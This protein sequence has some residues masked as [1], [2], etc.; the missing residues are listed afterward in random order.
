MKD[1]YHTTC[2]PY[3]QGQKN[4]AAKRDNQAKPES[5]DVLSLVKDLT[6]G[7][8][9]SP[10]INADAH[11]SQYHDSPRL[12]ATVAAGITLSLRIMIMEIFLATPM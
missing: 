1:G 7:G 11:C 3:S 10:Q 6:S 12:S 2:S 5:L 9:S 4:H 8:V